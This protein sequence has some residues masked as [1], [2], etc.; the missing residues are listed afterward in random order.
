VYSARQQYLPTVP[1]SEP[2][3]FADVADPEAIVIALPTWVPPVS[4]PPAVTWDGLQRKKVIV[5]VGAGW[6]PTAEIVATSCWFATPSGFDE[7][8]G[9]AV[10]A[11]GGVTQVVKLPLAKSFSVAVNWLDERVSARKF[12]KQPPLSPRRVVRSIPVSTKVLESWLV[13][14]HGV[15]I[16]LSFAI[17]HE[18]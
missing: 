12:V 3:A 2:L 16:V 6:P 13:G 1:V 4:Q 10:V 5:P 8:P 7:P 14:D 9:V 17:A 15:V 11:M 18:L